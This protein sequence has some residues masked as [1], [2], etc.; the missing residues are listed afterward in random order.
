MIFAQA[1]AQRSYRIFKAGLMAGNHVHIP[2]QKHR[3]ARFAYGRAC[4]VDTVEYLA[5]VKEQRF[6]GVQ[7]LRF[8]FGQNTSAETDGFSALVNNRKNQTSAEIIARP[9]RG[10]RA[11]ADVFELLRCVSCILRFAAQGGGIIFSKA[12]FKFLR[13]FFG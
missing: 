7:I 2:F 9:V 5:F 1:G 10:Q 3:S 6:G 13:G 4:K 12:Q 11:K 8:P